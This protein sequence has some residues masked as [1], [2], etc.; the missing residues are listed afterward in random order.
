VTDPWERLDHTAP[1]ELFG[2]GARHDFRWY[3]EGESD[4]AVLSVEEIT[5][6]LSE[7]EYASDVQIFHEDDFWQHPRTFEQLRRGDCEDFALWAWRKL[8]ELGLDAS[9]VVGRRVPPARENSR[10]AWVVFHRAGMDYL[11]EPSGGTHPNAV[12]PLG[13]VRAEYIPEAGVGRDGTPHLYAGYF[14]FI[15]NPDLGKPGR[16]S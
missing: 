11:L 14:Y 8:L 16:H 1:R 3:L 2:R 7:C 5:V 10:H 4:V 12:R 6:W 15:Q 9:L 13:D